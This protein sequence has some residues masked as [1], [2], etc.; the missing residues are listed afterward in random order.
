MKKEYVPPRAD[1]LLLAPCEA[2]AAW[3]WGFGSKWTGQQYFAPNSNNNLTSG[4]A[5]GGLFDTARGDVFTTDGFV[6]KKDNT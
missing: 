3:D 5:M 2:L 1:V 4:I 6:I